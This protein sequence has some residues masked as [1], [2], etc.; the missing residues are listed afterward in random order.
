MASWAVH[1]VKDRFLRDVWS[2]L[3]SGSLLGFIVRSQIM[4]PVA[5]D[6]YQ[7]AQK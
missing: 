6:L 2:C 7:E 5:C 4:E 3:D 1:V